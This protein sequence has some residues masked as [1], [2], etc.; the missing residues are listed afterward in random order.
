MMK[1]LKTPAIVLS[2]LL[3]AGAAGGAAGAAGDNPVLGTWDW[4]PVQGQCHEVHTYNADGTY[5]GESGTEV[6]TKTYTVVKASGGM[7]RVDATVTATNGGE[8][9]QGFRTDVEAK[10]TVYIQPLNGGG[11]FTCGSEDGMSCY[12]SAHLK[13]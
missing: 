13:K 7:Y 9:C 8:D 4:N 12:G 5:R 2:G 6:L 3:A 10:S 1:A 11:Y